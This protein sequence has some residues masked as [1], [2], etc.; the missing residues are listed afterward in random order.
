MLKPPCGKQEGLD[1]T[2][3]A[4]KRRSN[5]S[6]GDA[7][8]AVK[9]ERTPPMRLSITNWDKYNPR[10]DVKAPSWFRLENDFWMDPALTPLDS[11]GKI[12]WI[13][14]L[15]FASKRRSGEIDID[16]RFI[17]TVL[18][19]T[20]EKVESTLKHLQSEGRL[21][22]LTSRARN[23]DVTRT[24]RERD[25]DVTTRDGTGRD[26]TGQDGTEQVPAGSPP[27]EPELLVLEGEVIEP[28]AEKP[29]AAKKRKPTD[30]T[31]GSLVWQ[32]YEEAHKRQY[33]KATLERGQTNNALCAQLVKRVGAENAVAL[34]RFYLTHRKAYY[35]AQCHTLK[36]LVHDAEAL[37]IQMQQN[38]RVTN[39]QANAVDK[40][41]ANREVFERVFQKLEAEDAQ[42]GI[43]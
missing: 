25:V 29:K 13:T 7:V 5:P 8:R 12:V 9:S 15:S 43:A 34:V 10:S 22:I 6:V 39:T 28:E 1:E 20:H 21:K 23:V 31:P 36:P 3:D 32:A 40:D 14:L 33:P 4:D 42:R 11:D 16:P 37:L 26:G 2:G 18:G 27:Q 30:P 24:L 17:A 41:D 19:I 35:V 38:Q